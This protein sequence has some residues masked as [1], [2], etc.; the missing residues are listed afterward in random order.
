[1]MN[2]LWKRCMNIYINFHALKNSLQ[3]S[4]ET[5]RSNI[6]CF[7]IF[8]VYITVCMYICICTDKRTHIHIYLYVYIRTVVG[9]K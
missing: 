7:I 8:C 3:S 9:F 5:E 4:V 6:S 1:M 2:L